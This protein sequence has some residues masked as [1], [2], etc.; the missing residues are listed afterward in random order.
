MKIHLSLTT[1]LTILAAVLYLFAF[2]DIICAQKVIRKSDSMRPEWLTTHTP[3]PTN[4]SFHY[5]I[6]E[7]EGETL[8]E[9]R[10]ACFQQLSEYV[11]NSWKISAK[12]TTDICA[13]N[14]NGKYKENYVFAFQYQI[15]GGT[16]EILATKYD[17]YWECMYFPDGECYR[18]YVLF[19]VADESTPHFDRITFTPKYGARGLLRSIFI[20]GWG[21]MYKGSTVKG[22]CILGGEIVLA[23]GILVAENLRSSYVKK[24]YEQPNHLQTYNTRADN[25]ENVR[26]GFI[27]AAAAL[28]LY[29]IVDVLVA[30]GRKRTVVNRP[31]HLSMIPALGECNG[32]SL[33]MTF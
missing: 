20:P 1:V 6:V 30:N 10:R 27:G 31:V 8:D 24:M 4:S 33:V 29:N 3:Q 7:S 13:A 17:E 21:Q 23:G 32:M 14:S 26:N 22:L 9:A 16:V 15:D 11:E 25:W 5:Q 19:G 18:C 28:Y 2:S 12:S